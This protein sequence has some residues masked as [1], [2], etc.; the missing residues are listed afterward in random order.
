MKGKIN[1]HR[2][3]SGLI[4]EGAP[5][6]DSCGFMDPAVVAEGEKKRL[7]MEKRR[8]NVGA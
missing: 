5:N 6:K 7:G 4:F 2:S 8:P 1:E 3:G